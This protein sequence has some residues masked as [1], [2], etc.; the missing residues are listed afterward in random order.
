MKQGSML[1][2]RLFNIFINDL[3]L[4]LKSMNSGVKIS[5]F[6]LNVFAYADDLNLISTTAVGLQSLINKCQEYAEMWR[7]R[8]IPLKTNIICIGKQPHIKPPIWTLDNTQINLSENAVIL[9]VTFDSTLSATN[10]V[11]SRRRKCQQGIFK[12]SSMGLSY[13]GLNSDVKAFL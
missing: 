13:P 11:K 8:F 2:P 12:L 10:H 9:G 5:N 7:M 4:Q 6:H 3:L 1:S